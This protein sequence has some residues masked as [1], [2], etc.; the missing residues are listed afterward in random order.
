MGRTFCSIFACKVIPATGSDIHEDYSNA[1]TDDSLDA[2]AK[3]LFCKPCQGYNS[4]I[5]SSQSDP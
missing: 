2:F 5:E 1:F 3:V 4:G